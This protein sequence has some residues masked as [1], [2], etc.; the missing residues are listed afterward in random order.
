VVKSVRRTKTTRL[1]DGKE[2]TDEIEEDRSSWIESAPSFA[3]IVGALVGLLTVIVAVGTYFD[4]NGKGIKTRQ[5]EA[6]KP[7]F[8]KQTALYVDAMDTVSRIASSNVPLPADLNHFWQLYWGPLAAVE[9]KNVD[10]AMVIVGQHLGENPPATKECLT[11]ISLLL[12]HC[13]K[14]SWSDTWLVALEP[15]PELP[16]NPESFAT[17][18]LCK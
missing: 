15:S 2:I 10:R 17:V 16:C 7:F 6:K 9:D 12:A 8:E 5:F 14:Q 13:V 18:G 3:A 1:V 11:N 4:Q